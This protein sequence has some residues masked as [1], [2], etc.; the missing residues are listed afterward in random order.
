M[1]ATSSTHAGSRFTAVLDVVQPV[2]SAVDR[3]PARPALGL[4]LVAAGRGLLRRRA[5][6]DREAMVTDVLV[7]LRRC[8]EADQVLVVTRDDAVE[9]LAQGYDA[10]VVNDPEERPHS[11]AA[12]LGA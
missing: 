9:A 3:R 5:P 10:D 6:R 12:A 4:G 7:A 2:M 1:S 11:V 8:T